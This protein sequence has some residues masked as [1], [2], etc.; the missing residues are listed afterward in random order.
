MEVY[1]LV[2]E[3][4]DDKD[5]GFGEVVNNQSFVNRNL[6]IGSTFDYV[7]KETFSVIKNM[8]ETLR[9][10]EQI[11]PIFKEMLQL[12]EDNVTYDTD[13]CYIYHKI[14][15]EDNFIEI[16]VAEETFMF[17]ILSSGDSWV[18]FNIEKK[19]IITDL[20]AN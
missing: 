18:R 7:F 11:K 9:A 1:M 20:I 10:K 2:I 19:N 4:D 13:E 16:N 12:F 14:W 5:W 17:Y 8:K 15:Y 3:R 6:V